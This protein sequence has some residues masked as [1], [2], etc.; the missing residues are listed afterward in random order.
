MNQSVVRSLQRGI[1]CLG[2]AVGSLWFVSDV[3]SRAQEVA[4]EV[5]EQ[6]ALFDDFDTV[7]I[8]DRWSLIGQDATAS[9]V[10]APADSG[11]SGVAGKVLNVDFVPQSI[12]AMKQEVPWPQLEEPSAIRLCV[13]ALEANE[14]DPERLEIRVYSRERRA[15]RWYKVMLS[16]TSWQQL[17]LPLR[18]FRYSES[19][20]VDWSEA[21]RF[22]V[23]SSTQGSVQFDKIELVQDQERIGSNL[24]PNELSELA[25]GARGHVTIRGPFALITDADDLEEETILAKLEELQRSVDEMLGDYEY[26]EGSIPLIVF[27]Q[28]PDFQAFFPKLGAVLQA[29]VRPPR[30]QGFTVFSIACCVRSDEFGPIRPIYVHETCHA[31]LAERL[32]IDNSSEWLHEGLASHFQSRLMAQ[33]ENRKQAAADV[34]R[35]P[36]AWD[37]LLSGSPIELSDYAEAM[38]IIEWLQQDAATQERFV[39][40]LANVRQAGSTKFD[41]L[42]LEVCGKPLD[43]ARA[44][45]LKYVETQVR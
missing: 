22:A 17:E 26:E 19:S 43:E 4:Q 16:N 40:S 29:T 14:A 30:T 24:V 34:L 7:A 15:W 35:S 37:K 2:L 23:F 3:R 45:W 9:R 27:S 39:K 21:Q 11:I 42:I 44:D 38:F 6:T 18:W 1:S 5:E 20:H 25:F 31:L 33:D 8:G 10:D 32:G 41:E 13:R 36:A 12:L 28:E